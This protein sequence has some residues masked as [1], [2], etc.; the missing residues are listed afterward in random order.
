MFWAVFRLLLDRSL[1]P[2]VERLGRTCG[3]Q[4][5][6]QVQ[7]QVQT[8]TGVADMQTLDARGAAIHGDIRIGAGV[9]ADGEGVLAVDSLDADELAGAVV[10]AGQRQAGAP[11]RGD[12][13]GLV[14]DG[15]DARGN[16]GGAG[17]A[18]E[19]EAALVTSTLT[20]RLPVSGNR[21]L[22]T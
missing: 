13:A 7:A 19:N 16:R 15:V 2:P 22:V 21:A 14:G 6:G 11:A 17:A 3:V 9:A 1:R 10:G 18:G 20:A 4:T 5:C 8:R 12:D